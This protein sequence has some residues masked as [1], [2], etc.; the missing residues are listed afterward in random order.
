[1]RASIAW[2]LL[3]FATAA[4]GD[5]W[6]DRERADPRI[7][8]YA[9]ASPERTWAFLLAPDSPYAERRAVAA[10]AGTVLAWAD[11]ARIE[12]VRAELREMGWAYEPAPPPESST[13]WRPV[14]LEPPGSVVSILGHA[15]TIPAQRCPMPDDFEQRQQAPWPW[16]VARAIDDAWASIFG[17]GELDSFVRFVEALPCDSGEAARF[18]ERVTLAMADGHRRT[19]PVAIVGAWR[20]LL[21]RKDARRPLSPFLDTWAMRFDDPASWRYAHLLLL[22]H[23]EGGEIYGAAFDLQEL[24]ERI[25]ATPGENVTGEIPYV[26]VL[27]IS[28]RVLADSALRGYVRAAAVTYVYRVMG[29]PSPYQELGLLP[30]IEAHQPELLRHFAAWF[31]RHEDALVRG[32]AAQM[33]AKPLARSWGA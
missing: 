20:N 11:L 33:P 2:M 10:K 23:V 19:M 15:W 5:E 17:H 30:D 18:F 14:M 8:A 28:R 24:R 9:L 27:A 31:A 26:A 22:E 3:L 25:N 6:R 4:A 16:Q 13:V 29:E 32:A 12:A 1:M 7:V 21:L